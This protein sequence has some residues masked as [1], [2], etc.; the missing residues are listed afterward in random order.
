MNTPAAPSRMT[1][2]PLYLLLALA[3]V[4]LLG[5]RQLLR[6]GLAPTATVAGT[7]PGE[8]GLACT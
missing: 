7:Q 5:A 4:A 1:I 6:W 8:L 2:N 3:G